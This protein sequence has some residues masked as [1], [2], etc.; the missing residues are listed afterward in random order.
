VTSPE[1][2]WKF[3]RKPQI[4][5]TPNH[6]GHW[7]LSVRWYADW[8]KVT[9]TSILFCKGGMLTTLELL[10]KGKSIDGQ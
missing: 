10:E 3:L 5:V 4:M 6:G 2:V 9:L 7:F 8:D 1:S